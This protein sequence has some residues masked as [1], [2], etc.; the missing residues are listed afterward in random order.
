MVASLW[1]KVLKIDE[2]IPRPEGFERN[3]EVILLL[4]EG[5][6][7]SRVPGSKEIR[8]FRIIE[9]EDAFVDS[10]SS[11]AGQIHQ[12]SNYILRKTGKMRS[13]L[14]FSGFFILYLIYTWH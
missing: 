13:S 7:D 14:S 3:G 5:Q 6:L 12:R 9:Y 2:G 8:I 1:T 10:Y 11:F 4:Y